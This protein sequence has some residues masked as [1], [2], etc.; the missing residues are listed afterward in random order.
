[1]D[2]KV[3]IALLQSHRGTLSQCGVEIVSKSLKQLGICC[4][5][6]F[7]NCRSKSVPKREKMEGKFIMEKRGYI[8]SPSVQYLV[9][10]LIN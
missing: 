8:T 6:G 4:Q 5:D 2:W 10:V 7:D 9:S 1:M 3:H